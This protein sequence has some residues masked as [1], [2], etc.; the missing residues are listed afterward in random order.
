MSEPGQ[1]WL[2]RH[3]DTEWTA[4]GQHTSRTDVPLSAEGREQATLLGGLLGGRRFSTVL[5][6]PMSRAVD[7]C[8][9]AGYGDVAAVDDGLKEWDYGD[10]EARTTAEIREKNPGWTVW[11]GSPNGESL[12]DVGARACRVI[13]RASEAGGDAALFSHGH[14]LRILGATWIGLP[15]EGGRFLSLGTASLSILGYERE[16]R[17]IRQWNRVSELG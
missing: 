11:A 17:V 8:R 7:T 15:P 14:F 6:S 4:T 9:L 3:G 13:E 2:I 10:Y 5:S 1:L 16:A 12:Q